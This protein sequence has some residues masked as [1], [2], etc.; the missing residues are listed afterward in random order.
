MMTTCCFSSYESAHRRKQITHYVT[1]HT[2]RISTETASSADFGWHRSQ[3]C[4]PNET[5]L[6]ARQFHGI[7]IVLLLSLNVIYGWC[8][9][10]LQYQN[11]RIDDVVTTIW[12]FVIYISFAHFSLVDSNKFSRSCSP[13]FKCSFVFARIRAKGK[14]KEKKMVRKIKPKSECKKKKIIESDPR[15]SNLHFRLLFCF[16]FGNSPKIQTA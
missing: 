12:I 6:I 1:R 15:K 3:V 11:V 10:I 9:A 7:R 2:L 14:E 16:L 5:A 4:A 13:F 8:W